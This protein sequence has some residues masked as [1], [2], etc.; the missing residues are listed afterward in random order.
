MSAQA[1]VQVE[2]TA[3]QPSMPQGAAGAQ[4]FVAK[5]IVAAQKR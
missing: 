2:A 4:T 3:S 5:N 1:T